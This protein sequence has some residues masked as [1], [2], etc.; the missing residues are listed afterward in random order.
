[1]L[2]SQKGMT[3]QAD[4][5]AHLDLQINLLAE[6]EA[7]TALQLLERICRHLGLEVETYKNEEMGL[8]AK[9][10]V[11]GVVSELDSKLPDE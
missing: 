10:D 9:T 1:M 7:T 4:R 5:R 2:I 6:Q 11:R 8:A 3:R